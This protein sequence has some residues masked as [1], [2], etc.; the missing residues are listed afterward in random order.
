MTQEQFLALLGAKEVELFLLR[1]RVSALEGQNAQLS[2]QLKN[3]KKPEQD[4]GGVHVSTVGQ[5]GG[6]TAANL[7]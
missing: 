5:T 7:T 2:E 6:I 3:E 1:A 4:H